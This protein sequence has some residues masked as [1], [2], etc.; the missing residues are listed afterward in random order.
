MTDVLA[1]D[2][3]NDIKDNE[4]NSSTLNSTKSV[5]NIMDVMKLKV[6]ERLLI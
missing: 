4:K 2:G 3:T 5:R 1:N 6:R